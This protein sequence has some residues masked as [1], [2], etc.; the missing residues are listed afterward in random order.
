MT[1]RLSF[2]GEDEVFKGWAVTKELFTKNIGSKC[3]FAPAANRMTEK[4][5]K[6]A[7]CILCHYYDERSSLLSSFSSSG[8]G[9]SEDSLLPQEKQ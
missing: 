2:P 4:K 1:G 8:T 9:S 6:H 7:I 3:V 5:E